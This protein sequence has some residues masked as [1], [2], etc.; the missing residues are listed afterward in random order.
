MFELL[1]KVSLFFESKG[2]ARLGALLLGA[3][4]ALTQ[5]P[6]YWT[7]LIF[8]VFPGLFLLQKGRTLRARVQ[9]G[10]LFGLTYFVGTLY[11]IAVAFHVDLASF[12]WLTPFTVLG[13]PA[14][15][16]VL[17]VALPVGVYAWLGRRFF[18]GGESYLLFAACLLGAEWLR[19]HV[20][21]G[22]PWALW[23]Y[24]WSAFS[25]FSQ[26]FSLMGAYG[27]GLLTLVVAGVP[28]LFPLSSPT[29]WS[30][31]VAAGALL[32]GGF[33]WGHGRVTQ[34]PVSYVSGVGLRLVQPCVPQ[35][36]KW[37]ASHR[38]AIFDRLETMSR[39]S[40]E[41]NV[42][43]IIWPESALPFFVTESK[44]ALERMGDLVPKKGGAV[45]S[46]APRRAPEGEAPKLWTSLVAVGEGGQV[47]GVYDKHHL[48][49]FG[50]YVP[51][52]ALLPSF[53]KK[54]TAGT[55]DYS[56][57]VGARLMHVAP[58]PPF[59]PLICYEVIFPGAVVEKN[60]R[61]GWMLNI[62][63][64]AWYGRTSGPYQH[65]DMAR[66]RAIEEGLPL[67]RVANNGLSAVIDPLGRTEV[68]LELDEEGVLDARLPMALAPTLYARRGDT[69]YGLLLLVTM[70]LGMVTL[71]LQHKRKRP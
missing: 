56:P 11:W 18:K 41:D 4:C 39:L 57:G 19:G 32:F 43:H 59:A 48:V 5:A 36:L 58:L 14:F 33:W 38:R 6:V 28:L 66:M 1:K 12:W 22:F 47:K 35:S 54:V 68:R 63:N 51:G 10:F 23:G 3:L 7:F 20:L 30:A 69:L 16:S 49:P 64:D 40:L 70:L 71:H 52:R 67:V 61:P 34:T 53:V 65:F 21:T 13:L 8:L 2:R 29:R 37:E 60:T 27:M 55:M 44:G 15:L 9:L 17:F 25:S 50:E 42:T 24:T 45:L 46:G 31:F 26:L 62:T